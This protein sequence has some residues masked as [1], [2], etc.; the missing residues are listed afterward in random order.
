[1]PSAITQRRA[2]LFASARAR[3][4]EFLRIDSGKLRF[5]LGTSLSDVR[6]PVQIGPELASIH[7][8]AAA[9]VTLM[10]A[11]RHKRLLLEDDADAML[12]REEY[13]RMPSPAPELGAT[14][15]ETTQRLLNGEKPDKIER[16]LRAASTST[17]EN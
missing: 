7:A 13:A 8:S 1:M 3:P 11:T 9:E 17:S 16:D 10:L 2:E 15:H 4:T 14:Y 12:L 5:S 6:V